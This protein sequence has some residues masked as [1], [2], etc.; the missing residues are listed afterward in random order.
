[1][2]ILQSEDNRKSIYFH[3][4]SG[5]TKFFI[6]FFLLIII[7][8]QLIFSQQSL[9]YS[10]FMLN[11]YG[12]NPAACGISNNHIEALTGIRRQWVGFDNFPVSMFLNVNAYLGRKGGFKRVIH[13]LGAY[14]QMD[15]QGGLF[16]S[17][18][19]YASY[20]YHLRMMKGFFVAFGLA[21][22]ARRHV[23]EYPDK[24]DPVFANK[25][26]WIYPD[27]IPGIKIYSSKWAYDFSVKQLYK[28]KLKQ[29]S[30]VIGSP[31]KLTP[32]FYLMASHK[33]WAKTN[34]LIVQSVHI[35]HEIASLPS[36]DLNML[37]Y[38]RRNF[39]LGLSYRHLDAIIGMV[40]FRYDKLVIGF[41]YD[42]TIAP[43]RIGFANTQEIM[44]GISPSPYYDTDII[45]YRT[46]ECPNF[47]LGIIK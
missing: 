42:F 20:T 23:V 2:C 28:G 21:A 38:L 26:L 39:V 4:I 35:K 33:W 47:D 1:M 25:V 11:N 24:N 36:V 45:R 44:L 37:V 5:R 27:F 30:D 41:A 46:A 31:S 22:G 15:Q 6:F 40:Q 12:L 29:G 34:L 9:Q 10:Q 43:Y 8:C 7:N 18:S 17:D 3:T 14:W 19:Y 16:R 32:H 13:G